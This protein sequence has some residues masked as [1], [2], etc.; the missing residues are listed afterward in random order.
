MSRDAPIKAEKDYS[1]ILKQEFPKIDSLGEN[2]Y[3]A[4]LEQLSVWEKKVRQAADLISSKEV[5][6]KIVDLLATKGKWDELDE[7]LT[8]LSKKHGQLKLSIQHMVQK[9]MEY[10]KSDTKM[11]LNTRIKTIETIRTVTE[12]KIF[13]EVERARV[14]KELCQIKVDQKKLKEA[15]EILCELQVETY[16][17][18]DMFEKIEFILQQMELCILTNDFSQ[19]TVLSRKILKKTLNNPKYETLK[20]SYYELLIKIGLHKKEYLEIA[21][22]YQEVYNTDS[23]KN[24]ESKWKYALA[25][26][27]YFLVLS[28]YGNLQNDLVHKIQHDN[29]L[30]KLEAQES[31]IQLFTTQELMRWPIVKKTYEPVLSE[32]DVVFTEEHP[33][34]WEELQKRVIEHNLRVISEYYSKITLARLNELLDLS[35]SQTETY[36]SNLVNQGIIYAKVNRP[37]KIVNFEKPKESSELL[38]DWSRNIDELLENIE[39]I[40]H[41]IT[42]EE[43]M[44]GLKAK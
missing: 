1:E 17:S 24:E 26:I 16:G 8:L 28:P 5:L 9:I 21:Q 33:D 36:I 34:H 39:T 42:K 23:V 18:M 22:Y 37:A 6:G 7:Q 2:D 14:T 11:E 32:D 29:N 4:A 27:I 12:N 15:C 13:V 43:I 20:L 40:G 30:K 41:L 31:L 19:A 44:H 10:L 35:E 25:H 38:N 3:S